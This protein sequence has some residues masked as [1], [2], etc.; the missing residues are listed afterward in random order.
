MEGRTL[1]FLLL[2]VLYYSCVGVFRVLTCCD[3]DHGIDGVLSDSFT[4]DLA[5]TTGQQLAQ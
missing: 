5:S 1:F 2:G 3:L 4:P